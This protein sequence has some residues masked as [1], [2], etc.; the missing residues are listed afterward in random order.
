MDLA[1]TTVRGFS[2]LK[3]AFSK[4]DKSKMVE[5]EHQNHHFRLPNPPLVLVLDSEGVIHQFPFY[6][7]RFTLR[8]QSLLIDPMTLDVLNDIR[9]TPTLLIHQ[10]ENPFQV[11]QQSGMQ[12]ES[13]LRG[14]ARNRGP[15]MMEDEID[16]NKNT[17]GLQN[18]KCLFSKAFPNILRISK[19]IPKPDARI[20]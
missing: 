9:I 18:S 11:A 17:Q 10:T 14:L 3:V 2:F 7:T 15:R 8:E 20:K 5:I 16:M 19:S 6:D 4:E 13:E 12:D 1:G